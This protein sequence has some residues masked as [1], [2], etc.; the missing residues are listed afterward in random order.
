MDKLAALRNAARARG[1]VEELDAGPAPTLDSLASDLD[2]VRKLL[3]QVA[4][5][6]AEGDL[7]EA[8]K[9]YLQALVRLKAIRE[10]ASKRRPEMLPEIDKVREDAELAW[11][12][13]A[14]LLQEARMLFVQV[15]DQMA[16]VDCEAVDHAHRQLQSL[17]RPDRG[18]AAFRAR[19]D[20]PDGRGGRHA[21]DQV[22]HPPRARRARLEISGI[23]MGEKTTLEAVDS[24]LPGLDPVKFVHAFA[25]VEINGQVYRSGDTIAG[26]SIR[27][28]RITRHS[29]QVSLREEGEGR[30][31]APIKKSRAGEE[32]PTRDL[33]IGRSLAEDAA[34][35]EFQLLPVGDH[36]G[37]ILAGPRQLLLDVAV[38]LHD[39]RD[40]VAD[41]GVGE[42]LVLD[43]LVELG[44]RLAL[45]GV[46]LFHELHDLLHE[47]LDRGGLV[48]LLDLQVLHGARDALVDIA[49][50][51]PG[52]PESRA[53]WTGRP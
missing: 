6:K 38:A 28:G 7:E 23:M 35:E 36:V 9:T 8:R 39:L 24:P 49:A 2:G 12:G 46:E 17:P 30:R 10:L 18:R 52:S 4:A 14:Q 44:P 53:G 43:R 29:V 48:G 32:S 41:G 5:R 51:A 40:L 45:V 25:W 19:R 21:G 27:V 3:E 26:T 42:V 22:P 15:E 31:P 13:A 50:A 20:R 37:Q 47:A 16:R 11:D 33:G 34:P 1:R